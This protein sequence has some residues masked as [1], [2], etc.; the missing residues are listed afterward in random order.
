MDLV[1]W[2]SAVETLSR[3][4][5]KCQ[6]HQHDWQA[7]EDVESPWFARKSEGM[8]GD[9]NA[10]GPRDP[11]DGKHQRNGEGTP[12]TAL[13]STLQPRRHRPNTTAARTNH[14]IEIICLFRP[15]REACAPIREFLGV[16]QST[17]CMPL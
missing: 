2:A 5:T 14:Q 7:D 12:Q 8:S 1:A 16:P 11:D 17:R 10:L 13:A 6:K 15:P 9:R 3:R 4:P